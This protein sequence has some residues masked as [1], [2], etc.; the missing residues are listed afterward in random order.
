MEKSKIVAKNVA[1]LKGAGKVS[2]KEREVRMRVGFYLW[3]KLAVAVEWLLTVAVGVDI[4]DEGG[5][6]W[7]EEEG[8]EEGRCRGQR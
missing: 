7:K 2:E 1:V 4:G 6:E 3:G 5:E 8:G